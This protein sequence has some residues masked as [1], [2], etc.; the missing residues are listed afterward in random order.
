MICLFTLPISGVTH[1]FLPALLR[2]DAP[3]GAIPSD[4]TCYFYDYYHYN[5]CHPNVPAVESPD[6]AHSR[7]FSNNKCWDIIPILPPFYNLT[8]YSNTS[9][10]H[11]LPLQASATSLV[12]AWTASPTPGSGQRPAPHH[13]LIEV[14]VR[15]KSL[16]GRLPAPGLSPWRHLLPSY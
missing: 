2:G 8:F 12:G 7:L 9:F 13:L 15:E 1:S 14:I 4:T 16:P 6:S 3:L 5:Y 10:L 11:T